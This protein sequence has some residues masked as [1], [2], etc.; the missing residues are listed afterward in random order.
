MRINLALLNILNNPKKTVLSLAGIGTA[1]L[2]IFMQLGFRGAVEN[3]ATNIYSKM[4]YDI[5]IRS[6]DYLHFMDSGKIPLSILEDV[7]GMVGID[8]TN[9]MNVS[10]SNWRNPYTLETRG[11]LVIG[12]DPTHSPF[13]DPRVD[14]DFSRL[15]SIDSVLID[16]RSNREF[17]PQNGVRFSSADIGVQSEVS[18]RQIRIDGLFEL[19]AGLAAN[20]AVIVN[21]QGFQRLI[22][23]TPA[24]VSFGLVKLQAGVDPEEMVLQINQRL[25]NS[26]QP[27]A[28]VML[29]EESIQRELRRWLGETPIGYIFNLGVLISFGVGALIVYMVL[30]NDVANRIHEYATMRAMGYSNFFL[31]SVVLK[32]ALYLALFSFLPTLILSLVLYGLTS[33]LANIPI[34]MTWGRIGFVWLLTLIMSSISGTLALKKLWQVAP[35]ELF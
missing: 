16:Q 23:T 4:D 6:P 20:G 26:G 19:G 12:V 17:G 14:H 3:T 1:I 25:A 24:Q 10:V 22:L 29:R 8:S 2:L 5:L 13:K 35:A 27:T 21:Q 18:D 31:A 33:W 30:G 15:T 28:D 7:A 34:Q 11:I 32:Q 9:H